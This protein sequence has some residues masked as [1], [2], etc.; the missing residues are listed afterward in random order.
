ME[1]GQDPFAFFPLSHDP[2]IE[3]LG[4]PRKKVHL[5]PMMNL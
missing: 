3:D 1:P 2:Q 5:D 4:K